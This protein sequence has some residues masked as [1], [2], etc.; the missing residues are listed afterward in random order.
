MSPVLTYPYYQSVVPGDH[1]FNSP[2]RSLETSSERKHVPNRIE[3]TNRKA[4]RAAKA[5]ARRAR[6]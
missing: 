1:P 6:A 5:K 2:F 3:V 4:R